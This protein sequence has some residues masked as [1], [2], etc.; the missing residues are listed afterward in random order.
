MT[1]G[2]YRGFRER[3]EDGYARQIAESGAMAW[4]DAVEKAAADNARL[5]PK[6]LATPDNHL[7]TAYDG[8]IP[9]GR[10]WVHLQT[11]S[12]GVHAFIYDVE[13]REEFRRQGY[14]RAIMTAAEAACRDL[15]ASS[16]G[17]NVFGSNVA[18]RGLYDGLGYE[19]TSQQMRKRL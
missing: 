6:G 14:G 2:Q 7:W 8:S 10:I 5:L 13:V 12:D 1:D 11:R 9:V 16:M 19:V 4:E 3:V 15:G 17:L 18:A